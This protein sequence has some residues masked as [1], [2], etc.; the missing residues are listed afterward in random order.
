MHQPAPQSQ[1]AQ[2]PLV[3]AHVTE[4]PLKNAKN[5]AYMLPSTKNV[6][7]QDKAPSV[8]YKCTDPANR[9]LPLVHDP[10]I[11][12][13]VFQQSMEAL[14]TITQRELLS[15]S[16]EVCS[17][18]RDTTMMCHIPNKENIF[19]QNLYENQEDRDSIAKTKSLQSPHS[20]YL[21]H[22]TDLC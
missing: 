21:M 17:Q 9:T 19:T 18:V 8:P 11:A 22:I 12:A 20:Q 2:A 10:A 13:S 15:L 3:P 5:A 6:G 4:H 14:V 16:P 7:A 1:G